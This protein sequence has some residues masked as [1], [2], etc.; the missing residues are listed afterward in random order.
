MSKQE[1][2]TQDL[3]RWLVTPANDPYDSHPVFAHDAAEAAEIFAD[4]WDEEGSMAYLGGTIDVIV[5]GP[6]GYQQR[7][8][9]TGSM[10]VEYYRSWRR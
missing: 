3:T 8:T 10:V 5:I 2:N 1:T 7:F 6:D 4:E 9:V